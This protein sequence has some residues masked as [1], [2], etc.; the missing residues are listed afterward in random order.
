L[1]D[2]AE[3]LQVALRVAADARHPVLCVCAV[4][5]SLHRLAQR[6]ARLARE[7][8]AELVEVLARAVRVLF[9]EQ[10]VDRLGVKSS[11][12][13]INLVLDLFRA[14]ALEFANGADLILH[15]V[16][17]E[18]M[19]QLRAE[20]VRVA[21]VVALLRVLAELDG[22]R[23]A[24]ANVVGANLLDLVNAHRGGRCA[25]PAIRRLQEHV[26]LSL[27]VQASRD[28]VSFLLDVRLRKL[29]GRLG[30]AV[31]Q[32]IQPNLP[33]VVKPLVTRI[34]EQAA[35]A[36]LCASSVQLV[37][38]LGPEAAQPDTDRSHRV[39]RLLDLLARKVFARLD[40]TCLDL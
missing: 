30:A 32:G 6:L 13:R 33:F 16:Q 17:R 27:V 20:R 34:L 28:P 9:A 36:V 18:Q 4:L 31:G 19:V 21:G 24:P 11:S 40:A 7:V 23:L 3:N 29:A 8:V 39:A 37:L 38:H 22:A 14:S 5:G 12:R 1:G 35:V 26:P 15:H 25:D 10:T 2:A